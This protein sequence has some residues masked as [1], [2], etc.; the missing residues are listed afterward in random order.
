ME[1]I[2]NLHIKLNNSDLKV[3]KELPFDVFKSIIF[4]NEIPT[5]IIKKSIR[6]ECTRNV[7]LSKVE[8]DKLEK[9]KKY[10]P[11]WEKFKNVKSFNYVNAIFALVNRNKYKEGFM[12]L[13]DKGRSR[14]DI[15]IDYYS[16]YDIPFNL[17]GS[18][19]KEEYA[20]KY[21][22]NID[23]FNFIPISVSG[24]MEYSD[25]LE[26]TTIEPDIRK[27]SRY[28]YVSFHNLF[29]KHE[30]E[31]IVKRRSNFL[32]NLNGSY[33][34]WSSLILFKK[35]CIKIIKKTKKEILFI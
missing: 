9:K 21:D 22:L 29:I 10:I 12:W 18:E 30:L 5:V 1:N 27:V 8:L 2:S 13:A 16:K 7:L 26:E 28:I 32:K 23:N 11:Y 25:F 3:L 31:P 15:N 24:I 4:C 33:R 35:K 17:I 20:E 34:G 19:I 6:V 14:A